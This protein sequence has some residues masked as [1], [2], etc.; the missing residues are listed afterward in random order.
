MS[1]PLDRLYDYLHSVCNHD[2]LI[3][4]FYPHGSRN[5]E[6]C[7]PVNDSLR[8][9][10]SFGDLLKSKILVCHDQEPLNFDLLYRPVNIQI[11]PNTQRNP[12][13]GCIISY[14]YFNVY[15]KV[16]LCHSELN[17][18][19]V[20]KF[21]QHGC[22]DVYY[23]A[24]AVIARD[25]FRYAEHEPKLLNKSQTPKRFL[26][27]NRAWSGTREYRLKFAEL[28]IQH[29]LVDQ[30]LTK[31]N[32]VDQG[33]HYRDHV[34]KNSSLAINNQNLENYFFPNLSSSVSSA[35]FDTQDYVNTEI[36]IVLETLF[37]DVRNHL[38]EKSLRPI[39]CGQPFILASTPG[40]LEYL[41]SYGFET[42]SSVF[43]ESYDCEPDTA[44]RLSKIITLMQS[45]ENLSPSQKQQLHDI[46]QRN[47]QRFF[48][49]EF[50]KCVV[51]EFKK[52]LDSAT[53][54]MKTHCCA[55]FLKYHQQFMSSPWTASLLIN[56][57]DQEDYENLMNYVKSVHSLD[58]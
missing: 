39:A 3:Y 4:R 33:V 19:E 43:D 7:K 27:Y 2:I 51:D 57:K 38:T 42:F 24:H 17:S 40:S 8:G 48:S 50:Q 56:F 28:L 23:W 16:M 45:L 46:A 31:F 9:L 25:W 11:P 29:N 13:R 37:D 49:A 53:E 22:I 34:F 32:P 12:F 21:R 6:D 30:C 44:V 47:K 35:D 26:I 36:E 54:Q 58:D 5:L 52:N 15:D 14:D 41:K 55:S 1:V 20:E 18:P 10:K